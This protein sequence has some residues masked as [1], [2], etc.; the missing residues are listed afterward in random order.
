MQVVKNKEDEE[1]GSY[2]NGNGEVTVKKELSGACFSQM[3]EELKRKEKELDMDLTFKIGVDA[4]NES[5][6]I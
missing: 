1:M 3:Q 4:T 6:V 5:S 2:V